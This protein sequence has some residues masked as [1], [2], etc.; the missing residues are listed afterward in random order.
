MSEKKQIIYGLALTYS[1]GF[2]LS[3]PIKAFAILF[4]YLS[5]IVLS[6]LIIGSL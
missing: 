5:S 6:S 4:L 3:D 2:F 1:A